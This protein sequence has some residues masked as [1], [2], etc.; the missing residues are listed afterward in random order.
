MTRSAIDTLLN[1]NTQATNALILDPAFNYDNPLQSA[2]NLYKVI[3]GKSKVKM[4]HLQKPSYNLQP[5]SSCNDWNPTVK[6]G[7]WTNELSTENFELNGEQCPDEFDEKCAKLILDGRATAEAGRR[8]AG[9]SDLQ[10]AIVMLVR[11]SLGDDFARIIH[12]GSKDFAAKVTAGT[13]SLAAYSAEKKAQI[14]AMMSKV[15]GLWDEIE[16]RA[17]STDEDQKV[18]LF[19]TYDGTTN[20]ATPTNII[21]FLSEMHENSHTLLQAMDDDMKVYLLQPN[22]YNALIK[23]YRSRNVESAYQLLINGT[24]VKNATTFD[25]IPVVKFHDWN[26]FDQEVGI[27]GKKARAILTAKE[28]VTVL[29][30]AETIAGAADSFVV[31]TSPL[32]K[33]KGKTWMYGAWGLDAGIAQPQL[34]TAAVNSVDLP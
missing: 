5:K 22:M 12:F 32:I 18:R 20:A 3:T 29:L 9:L 26:K 16:A 24:A 28:N 31:Q 13:Y 4:T 23:N 27:T 21:D 25:G 17:T 7:K 11:E 19:D 34:I 2:L 8:N 6:I 30:N 33:D 15:D 10:A 1:L 14:I